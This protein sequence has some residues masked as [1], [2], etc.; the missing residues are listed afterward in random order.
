MN[1][2]PYQT[3]AIDKMRSLMKEGCRSILYQGATGSG[4]TLLTAHMLHTAA[5]KGMRS[6]FVVHRKELIDQS[7]RAFKLEGLQYGII[8][9]G[10]GRDRSKLVQI[11]SIGTLVRR[12]AE[13]R[14]PSLIVWDECHHIAAK[15]WRDTYSAFPRAYHVGLTAT[16]QRL[17]GQGLGQYFQTLISG[18]SVSWLIENGFLSKYRLYAPATVDLSQVHRRMGDYAKDELNKAM[19]K[20]K[21][22]GSAVEHYKKYAAGKRAIVFA[23]SIEHSKHIVE[24][25]RK[26]GYNA[27][28]VDGETPA[29]ER[30]RI[31]ERF[32][33]G[34]I[35]ILSNVELFGEGFDIPAVEVAILLRPTESLGLYLQQCGRSLRPFD[36]KQT[37]ILLD[38]VGN[39]GRF[40]LPDQDREW[41]LE[42]R[43]KSKGDGEAPVRICPVCFGAQRPVP[44]CIFCGAPFPLKPREIQTVSGDLKEI[45][46]AQQLALKLRWKREQGQSKGF[47]E[48]VELGKSRGYKR[49]HAWAAMVMKGRREKV[50]SR[51]S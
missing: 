8:A 3:E 15:S 13:Y 28:H 29:E 46:S 2:R 17:D 50:L 34:N 27:E 39:V 31:V 38:H 16:P 7:V 4:K 24:E 42:G 12:L 32:R 5:K 14:A 43:D 30:S 37:A 36:G 18:P 20:P 44:R 25:F 33:E 35:Q 23:V 21:I 49:P 22:T 19:D 41:S 51:A 9:A 26:A 40:G 48:L 45:D 6:W 10:Y 11:A 1:L 47:H